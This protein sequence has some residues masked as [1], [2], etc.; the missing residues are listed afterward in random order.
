M[1]GSSPAEVV[2]ARW[3]RTEARGRDGA[4]G[5][6]AARADGD[7]CACPAPGWRAPFRIPEEQP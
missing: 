4:R 7:T 1:S 3:E 6:R 5:A 2:R